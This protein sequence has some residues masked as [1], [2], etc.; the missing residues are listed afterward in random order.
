VVIVVVVEDVLH[1]AAA[2]ATVV[3]ETMRQVRIGFIV[4]RFVR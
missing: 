4:S 1:A 2:N 3:S